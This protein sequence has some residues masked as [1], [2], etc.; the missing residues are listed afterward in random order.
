MSF[1]GDKFSYD[2]PDRI[3]LALDLSLP[4][5]TKQMWYNAYQ[6]YA[7]TGK[8]PTWEWFSSLNCIDLDDIETVI[9]SAIERLIDTSWMM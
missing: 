9:H 8:N 5:W 4:S 1:T 7:L 2:V 6:K 3:C